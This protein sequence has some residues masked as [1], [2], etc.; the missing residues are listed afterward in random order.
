MRFWALIAEV[1]SDAESPF[2]GLVV[3]RFERKHLMVG[4]LLALALSTG[5][6]ASATCLH[7]LIAWRFVQGL[8]VPVA[9]V[10]TL[11][12]INETCSEASRDAPSAAGWSGAMAGASPSTTSAAASGGRCRDFSGSSG[13]GPAAWAWSCSSSS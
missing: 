9:Y 5:C 8:F 11:S 7:N 3:D 13:G 12:Y 1:T 6:A 2:V 4:A 10:V